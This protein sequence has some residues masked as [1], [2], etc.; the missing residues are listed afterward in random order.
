MKEQ[1]L[2]RFPGIS[3]AYAD[4]K[5]NVTTNVYGVSDVEKNGVADENTVF[6]AYSVSKFVTAICLMRLYDENKLSYRA[7]FCGDDKSQSGCGSVGIRR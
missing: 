3:C 4:E 5:G 2:K 7:N 6:P 1:I